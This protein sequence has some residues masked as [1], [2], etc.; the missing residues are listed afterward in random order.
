MAACPAG[1]PAAV[2]TATTTS[3]MEASAATVAAASALGK[4]CWRAQKRYRCDCCEKK[5]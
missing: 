5:L 2:K 4:S 3:A 1:T